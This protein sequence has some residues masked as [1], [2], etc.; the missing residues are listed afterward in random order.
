MS[1][2]SKLK[3]YAPNVHLFA[4]QLREGIDANFQPFQVPRDWVEQQYENVLKNFPYLK[5]GEFKLRQVP[6]TSNNFNLLAGGKTYRLFESD[7]NPETGKPYQR[8]LLYPQQI[9]DSY[10]LSFDF[11]TP[12]VPGQDS[13]AVKDLKKL[14]PNNCLGIETDLGKT[15]LLTAFIPETQENNLEEIAQ[16]CLQ[17]LLELPSLE[18]IPEFYRQELLFNSPI[19]EYGNPRTPHPDGHFLLLFFA[20]EDNSKTF[21]KIYW[22]LPH[23]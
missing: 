12:Q 17:S 16:K 20:N 19:L 13:L 10:A 4:F 14:N 21:K 2:H 7:I 3:I 8:L 1:N 18:G 11:S 6:P 22:Q 9:G 15:I 5:G 23:L